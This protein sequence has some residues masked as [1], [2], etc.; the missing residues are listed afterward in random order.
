MSLLPQ[1][2]TVPDANDDH[3]PVRTDPKA[4]DVG[5]ST[6]GRENLSPTGVVVHAASNL[7]KLAE[8]LGRRFDAG[9]HT[10]RGLCV[11]FSNE[12]VQV[13][14]IVERFG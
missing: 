10:S 14:N 6:E 7:R 12:I 11:L 2:A 13:L 8:L 9:R 1:L 3:V 5:A 4:K